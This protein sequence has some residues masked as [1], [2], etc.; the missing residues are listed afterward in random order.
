MPSV[1]RWWIAVAGVCMQM[2]LGA[3]YAWSVFRIPLVKEFGWSIAQV[4]STFTICWFV[5]GCTSVLGGLWMNRSGPRIVAVAGSIL[6]GSGVF[7]TSLSAHKLWLLYLSYGVIGGLGLGLGYIVPVAVLVKW[8]PE[9]RGLITGIAVAGFGAGALVAAPAAGKLMQSVGL[10]P[11]FAYLGVAYGIVAV[12]GALFMQN[13][14]EGWHPAGWQPTALQ[15]SQ[16]CSRDFTLGEALRTWQWWALCGLLS[17][18][19]MAGLSVVSQAAPI[20][21]EIGKLSAVTAAALVGVISIGNGVGRVLWSWIS[22]LTTRRVAFL[23]MF[24][25][26]AV[27]FWTYH[28]IASPTLLTVVTFII[29]MCYGGGYGITPAFAAD[30]FGPRHVGPIFGL[31]LLPWAFP[32]ALG[33][34][35]FA[36]LRETTG[37]Y[38]QALYLIAG[39]LTIAMV[40][41][42]IVSPPR[43][44][45]VAAETP[46]GSAASSS[47]A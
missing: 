45:Q 18:N 46:V 30:Y 40:L 23:T 11:T 28:Y 32:A 29:V 31:M 44:H 27:L 14:P 42:M 16:R 17:I 9:R 37:G 2:A 34:L 47:A 24:L 19:T 12:L 13:P 35:L 38:T 8:F 36:Y 25:I 39:M 15:L 10:M 22:D 26:Q 6:W 1:N 20:F 33:P 43:G 5:L 41:P 7:L 3:A 4:S 21:Q